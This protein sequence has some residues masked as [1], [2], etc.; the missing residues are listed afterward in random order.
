M[1][2]LIEALKRAEEQRQHTTVDE[3]SFKTSLTFVPD[4]P[5]DEPFLEIDQEITL[6]LDTPTSEETLLLN[7]ESSNLI[8]DADSNITVYANIQEKSDSY[9]EEWL[10]LND[11][12]AEETP[13][14]QDNSKIKPNIEET[15]VSQDNSKIKLNIEETPVSQDNSKIKLNIEETPVSQDNSKIKLNIEETFSKP[16]TKEEHASAAAELQ[17][18]HS[19]SSLKPLLGYMALLLIMLVILGG[20][21]FFVSQKVEELDKSSFTTSQV[22]PLPAGG[23]A[24][25]LAEMR[26]KS[27][28]EQTVTQ[29]QTVITQVP[30]VE[31][32]VLVS[33]AKSS[34][35]TEQNQQITSKTSTPNISPSTSQPLQSSVAP[36]SNKRLKIEH[37]L[38]PQRVDNRL[39]DAYQAYQQGNYNTAKKRYLLVLQEDK[40]NRDALL[41][42]AGIAV[43]NQQFS[44]AK[45]YYQQ[46]LQ[47]YPKDSVAEIGLINLQETDVPNSENILK[48]QLNQEPESANLQFALGNFYSRQHRWNEAQQAYFEAYR[49]NN[50]HPDYAYNL[51]VSLE[52]LGKPQAAL[53]YYQRALTLSST[54]QASFDL[55]IVQQRISELEKS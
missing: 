6:S 24:A 50:Q 35:K 53:P 32:K 5:P 45:H 11:L 37:N 2:L 43:Q 40:Y 49:H 41:G 46:V 10:S 26:K 36:S 29:S 42:L 9:N 22:T 48:N 16:W 15:P 38:T 27:Q 52:Q 18:A 23:L 12:P 19:S 13:V 17:A 55:S 31:E 44:Q 39:Q 8:L 33:V 21:Y 30:A 20:G 54:H 1:S 7:L 14:S 51:A 4:Q 25:K 3:L 47:F 28:S 34:V